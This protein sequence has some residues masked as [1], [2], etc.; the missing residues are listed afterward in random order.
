M[1]IVKR[2]DTCRRLRSLSRVTRIAPVVVLGLLAC[3]PDRSEKTSDTKN[4]LVVSPPQHARLGF[5]A[6]FPLSEVRSDSVPCASYSFSV[7]GSADIAVDMGADLTFAYDRANIL[8]GGNVPVQITYT[9][10][11]DSGPEVRASATADVMMGVHVEGGCIAA[12][13][14]VD[15]VSCPALTALAIAINSFDGQ[16]NHFSLVS[17]SGDFTA[18][19]GAVPPVVVL[20][21]GDTAVLQFLGNDLL[22][23]TPTASLTLA[24]SPPGS[25]PGFGGAAALVSASGASPPFIPLVEWDSSAPVVATITL[26]SAPGPTAT[27]TLNPLLH[28]LG[29]SASASININLVGVLGDVF[30]QPSPISVFSGALGPTVGLDNLLCNSSAIPSIAQPAC[31]A[32]VAAGN[33]PYPALQPQPPDPLPAVPPLPPFASFNFTIT[34]DSDGDGLLDGVELANGTD[35]DNADTDHDG[36]SDGAEVNT[37]GTDP[38]NPDT[39]NDGLSDGAEVNTYHTNPLDPDTDHDL[40]SDGF[41]VAH[42]TDPLDPDSDHDGIIDGLDTQSMNS[43][44]TALPDSAFKANGQRVAL[45]SQLR[46]VERQV[47]DHKKDNAVHKLDNIRRHLDGCP[48]EPDQDDW[49]TDCTAQL[50]LRALLDV[51]ANNLALP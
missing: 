45:L 17:A 41:E 29:T 7:N 21:T 34:L 40:L 35:P 43:F 32:T 18:P 4:N 14:I 44:I 6:H 26:P 49:V 47:A 11:N 3:N 25:F 1:A 2:W 27:M 13:C 24:P 38:L 12:L 9:P 39:D 37:Y 33:V 48:T 8:P 36:L 19:L 50:E 16:L 42:G 5:T 30:G 28:W 20:G 31:M 22:R 15:P 46:D 51:L 10:T 23:V